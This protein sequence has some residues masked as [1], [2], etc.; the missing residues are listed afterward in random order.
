MQTVLD[1]T[2]IKGAST[3][4]SALPLF[5]YGFVL[6]KAAFHD[7][8]VLCYGW[9]LLVLGNIPVIPVY[10]GMKSIPVPLLKY[11]NTVIAV[12]YIFL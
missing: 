10:R 8:I 7:A 12:N 11:R 4:L 5:E 1:H 2:T 3:W 9:P 6:H